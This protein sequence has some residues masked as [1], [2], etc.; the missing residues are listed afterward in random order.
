MRQR[1]AFRDIMTGTQVSYYRVQGKLGEGGMGVVY[2]AEDTRLGR[3]VA[4]KFLPPELARDPQALE[5]FQREARAA[6]ALNH[7]NICTIYDVGEHDGASFIAMEL[8]DGGTLSRRIAGQALPVPELLE[9]A[10]QIA[11]ALDAAHQKGIVHRDIKPANIFVTERGQAKILDFG[12]AKTGKRPRAVAGPQSAMATLT[13]DKENLTSP[14]AAVGTVAYMSP[15]QS[16]GEE[17]DPR[18]DL[19]SFGCVLYEMATGRPAFPGNTS[20]V[21]FNAILNSSPT[22]PGRLNP[23]LPPELDGV[24][25]K[26]LEKDRD[27]R[28][29]TAA[30]LR[31]DL[32][33]IKRDTESVRLL[34]TAG[35]P[36]KGE[37]KWL[38]LAVASALAVLAGLYLLWPRSAMVPATAWEQITDYADSVSSPALSPDGHMLAFLRGPRTFTTPGQ[39][40]VMVL[41][42]GPTLQLTHDDQQ[43]MSPVF[44]PDGAAIAYTVPFDT[45]TVSVSGGQPR[46]WLPNASALNWVDNNDLVFSEMVDMPRMRITASDASRTHPRPV[47][48]PEDRTGMAHRSYPSPDRKWVLVAAEMVLRPPWQWLPCRLAPMQ[49]NSPGRLVGPPDAACTAA[50]WSPD[51]KWM[52]FSSNAGGGF[53]IWRQRFP[54]GKPEQMTS[55]PTEEEG[56]AVSADGKSLITAV[57]TRRVAIAVHDGSGERAVVSEGRPALASAHNGSPFSADGKKLY[58][59]ELPRATND[60]GSAM[61]AP[62]IAGELWEADLQSG[63]TQAVFP[64]LKISTFSLE[65]NGNRIVFASPANGMWIASLDHRSSPRALPPKSFGNFRLAAEYIYYVARE[66][67]HKSLHRMRLDGSGDETVWQN[68]FW[69]AAISPSGRYLALTMRASDSEPG[70]RFTTRIVDWRSG[71]ALEVC[72]ECIGWWTDDGAWFAISEETG[73]GESKETYLLPAR[74]GTELPELPAGGLSQ[75][76]DAAHTKG[77]RATHAPVEVALGR[78]GDSYAVLRETVQRNLYRIPIR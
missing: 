14:G 57:G 75:V 38:N 74:S 44:S 42:K 18:S 10:I 29:Q 13:Q 65:P 72:H 35:A 6:S 24:I 20:A 62:Y 9:L 7:P 66:Q 11:D 71:H 69:N 43:K 37:R 15:E 39:V 70:P 25:A 55:G 21:I 48:V 60:V 40:F 32:R 46:L 67:N 47:Y 50:A 77:A 3:P 52:Y 59:L 30:E 58:Y 63:Q 2:A 36:R 56:L 64:G 19:F 51:G 34:A 78:H 31:T 26:A 4:L 8:L 61:L 33:R 54:E 76:S 73:S 22:A 12:L 45:W 41:P 53:H 27:L 1:G 23:A 49:G 16:C 17:L 28:Y 5:R 68:D